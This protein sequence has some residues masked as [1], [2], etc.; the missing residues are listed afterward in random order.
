MA[1]APW[2][3]FVF[4]AF[5]Q[6]LCQNGTSLPPF[7]PGCLSETPVRSMPAFVAMLW[8]FSSWNHCSGLG[9]GWTVMLSGAAAPCPTRASSELFAVLSAPG[10]QQKGK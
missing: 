2:I 5:G 4:G 7:S 1:A 3:S 10:P 8:A 9:N 6:L